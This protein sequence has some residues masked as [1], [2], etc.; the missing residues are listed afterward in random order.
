[1]KST[2]QRFGCAGATALALA[3]TAAA[4][5]LEV[6]P[7]GSGA[8]YAEIQAAIDAAHP[9]DTIW[10]AAG[11]YAPIRIDKPLEI[12]GAGRDAVTVYTAFHT[13]PVLEVTGIPLSSS[14]LVSGLTVTGGLF[15]PTDSNGLANLHDCAGSI[16]L[17][18]VEIRTDGAAI[19]AT[20]ALFV[21]GCAWV[22]LDA[23]GVENEALDYNPFVF[24]AA[25]LRA[26]MKVV[27]STVWL[28]ASRVQ[29]GGT[30]LQ[31][32]KEDGL[33]ALLL[34]DSVFYTASSQLLGGGGGVLSF[35]QNS[36]GK[37]GG[38]AV[39]ARG[40][41]L[42]KLV[43]GPNSVVASGPGGDGMG[44]GGTDGLTPTNVTLEDSSFVIA[45]LFLPGIQSLSVGPAAGA[46]ISPTVFPTLTASAPS[47]A[48]GSVLELETHGMPLTAALVFYAFDQAP[49]PLAL[50]GID[51]A[52]A[53]DPSSIALF[54]SLLNDS[55]G[56]ASL[57]TDVPLVPALVGLVLHFQAFETGGTQDRIS[58][59][60]S[61]VLRS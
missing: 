51:G 9:G 2:L 20:H 46:S 5:T 61:V 53:L 11:T 30:V 6:G 25:N 34:E 33:G 14:V 60:L 7:A 8:P 17:H 15:T 36:V 29:G 4:G 43:G 22:R 40:N 55:T 57:A 39:V 10:V 19:H 49:A 50:P 26:A 56:A 23:A 28:N 54:G 45:S 37:D 24:G 42:L 12:L 16:T 48:L 21:D 18:D 35:L 59:P 13:A 58:N 27:D 32:Q 31:Q 1:M 3:S 44:T 52:V 41:S 47:P 38:P